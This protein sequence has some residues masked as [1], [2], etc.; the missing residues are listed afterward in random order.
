MDPIVAGIAVKIIKGLPDLFDNLNE[1][2]QAILESSIVELTELG[3]RLAA[4]EDPEDQETITVEIDHIKSMLASYSALESHRAA[5][6]SLELLKS[7][8]TG[9]IG[10]LI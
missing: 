6:K 8:L 7:T 3:L 9:A 10:G 1:E 5:D 2:E 4:A